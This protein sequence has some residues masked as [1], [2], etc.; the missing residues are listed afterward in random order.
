MLLLEWKQCCSILVNYALKYATIKTCFTSVR[1]NINSDQRIFFLNTLEYF[2]ICEK[3]L[4][5][6]VYREFTTSVFGCFY[7]VFL[8]RDPIGREIFRI[9]LYFSLLVFILEKI[10][11]SKHDHYSFILFIFFKKLYY[12][13]F[14]F[15]RSHIKSSFLFFVSF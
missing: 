14:R 13:F 11:S 2:H 9:K 15:F 1:I 7:P 4:T 8:L 6:L 3:R 12:I 10:L 5:W